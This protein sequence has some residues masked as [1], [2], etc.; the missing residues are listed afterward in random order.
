MNSIT[1]TL[2]AVLIFGFGSYAQFST[3]RAYQQIEPKNDYRPTVRISGGDRAPGD[4]I[5]ADDFSDFANW[6]VYTEGGTTPEWELVTSTPDDVITF[7]AEMDSPTND[8]GFAC[9]NGVQYLLAGAVPPINAV[10][11]YNDIIDCSAADGV[12][13]SFFA[14]YRA[15]NVERIYLEVTNDDWASYQ[16]FELYTEIPTNDQIQDFISLNISEVASGSSEVKIRF[17]FKE[18]SGDDGYGG[19]Y[20]FMI[21]DFRVDEAWSYDLKATASYH[22]SGI[23]MVFE[24]GLEYYRIPESQFTEISFIGTVSNEGSETQTNSKLNT[25]V[26]GIESYT[27]SSTPIDLPP[28]ETDSVNCESAFTPA[29]LGLHNIMYWFDGDNMDENTTNDTLYS[30]PIICTGLDANKVYARDNYIPNGSIG[31]VAGNSGL[32]LLIGNVMNIFGND[33]IGSMEIQI[34]DDVTNIDQLIFGQIM[35][36]DDADGDFIYLDQTAD[37]LIEADENGTSITVF[38]D[39]YVIVEAGQTIIA[40]AGHYGGA[41]EVRFQMAQNVEAQTVLGYASGD[42]TPFFLYSPKAI[43]VRVNMTHFTDTDGDGISDTDEFDVDGDGEGP[44]DTDG[45]GIFD[46][47]DEDDDGDG[48]PTE[49]ETD[50]GDTDGDGIDDYLD[51]DDD[52]DGILTEDELDVDGDGGDGYDD[53][54]GDGIPD[55]LDDDDDGDG[56]LTEDEYDEDGDG[57]PDD[58][59]GDG[60]PDYLDDGDTDGDGLLDEVEFDVDGD[61][62][63]PDDTDG[64]GIPDYLDEDDDGDGVL[65]EDEIGEGDTDG[66]GILDYLDIDDDGDGVLTEDEIG[67]GDTDEDGIADYLDDDDDGDGILTEDEYDVDGDGSPDDTD[68]DGVPDYLDAFNTIGIDTDERSNFKFEQ[69]IPNPFSD[70]TRFNF[71]LNENADVQVEI[72][73]ISGQLIQTINMG[74]LTTGPHV[75]ELNASNYAAGTYFYAFRVNGVPYTGMMVVSGN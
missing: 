58:V 36:L 49:D 45:D 29:T 70:V 18:L 28:L 44:D 37:H 48:V 35:L 60:I 62:D 67:E 26:S 12:I 68:G 14:A 73:A 6:T 66:D 51:D 17:R 23:G 13:V 22:R 50:E 39:D 25:V 19:G 7:F 4:L 1:L 72:M 42:V 71:E 64:D 40:L 47:L 59:D 52:G 10:V 34:T 8:N 15:F 38:F 69:N 9:F 46:Y 32:P 3:N 27:G 56:I 74:S 43:M 53:T 63:G 20:A 16:L 41:D 30:V 61:G 5:I 2:A 57:I 21:D 11:E 55:Y 65:T 54:D 75:L 31:N 24:N 33:T